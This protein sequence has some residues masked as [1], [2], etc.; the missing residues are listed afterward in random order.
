MCEGGKLSRL[1]VGDFTLRRFVRSAIL[2]VALTY[3][4]LGLYG[5]LFT[6]RLAFQPPPPTYREGEQILK[7][8][9]SD[10]VAISAVH[11]LNPDALFTIL[12][13]HGNAE[14]L[15][16]VRPGLEEL[17]RLGFSVFA[18]D[19]RGYGTSAGTPS[20]QGAYADIDAAY[21]YLTG[22]LHVPAHRIIVYG[23]SLGGAVAIDLATRQPVAGLIVESSFVSGFRVLT[24]IPLFPF[25]KF[26]SIEKITRVRYPVLVIHGRKDRVVSFWH[27]ER[28]F[29]E[30]HEPKMSLWVD[31]AGHDDVPEAG[32]ERYA[33]ALRKFRDLL[34]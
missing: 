28:L 10:G 27:G 2:I 19:Y 18:F 6:D 14:D 1:L 4:G 17:R 16:D 34:R 23:R 32:A 9:A 20:E 25:D 11:L 30:A 3:V 33:D 22:R 13:A 7:L 15:G 5:Y 24:R 12:Y 8:K 29:R 26:R 21:S 31:G